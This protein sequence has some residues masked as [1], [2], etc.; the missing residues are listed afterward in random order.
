VDNPH[1]FMSDAQSSG[2]VALA[3]LK[4]RLVFLWVVLL[5]GLCIGWGLS[6]VGKIV[7]KFGGCGNSLVFRS[8]D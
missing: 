8:I 5:V 3:P 2:S 1:T 6:S 4:P 7:D